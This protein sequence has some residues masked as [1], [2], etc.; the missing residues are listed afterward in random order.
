MT[1]SL[2]R[3]VSQRIAVCRSVSQHDALWRPFI[4]GKHLQLACYMRLHAL[5]PCRLKYLGALF[6]CFKNLHLKHKGGWTYTATKGARFC[7]I[8]PPPSVLI[9]VLLP[10]SP[11]FSSSSSS[12][13]SFSSSFL[14]SDFPPPRRHWPYLLLHEQQGLWGLWR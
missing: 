9:L 13:S 3:S 7:W 14:S 10:F 11:P 4:H 5:S 2:Y 8:T 12:S 6:P 1:Y